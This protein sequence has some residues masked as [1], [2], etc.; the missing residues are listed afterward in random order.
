MCMCILHA[1]KS[2]FLHEPIDYTT[3]SAM[4]GFLN[5]VD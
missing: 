3:K 5:E 1:F 2:M 4:K